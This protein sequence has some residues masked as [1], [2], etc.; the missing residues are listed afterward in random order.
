M[1]GLGEGGGKA[2]GIV[3]SLQVYARPQH[4]LHRCGIDESAVGGPVAPCG[5]AGA[6][7]TAGEGGAPGLVDHGIAKGGMLGVDQTGGGVELGG[8]DGE[9]EPARDRGI[10]RGATGLGS[11]IVCEEV[12]HQHALPADGRAIA[13]PVVLHP[14]RVEQPLDL[15]SGAGIEG[16]GSPGIDAAARQEVAGRSGDDQIVI[17]GERVAQQMSGIGVIGDQVEQEAARLDVVDPGRRRS[18]CR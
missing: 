8:H 11:E 1:S 7:E 18:R 5:G 16:I 2:P 10:Q 4:I 12:S 14:P 17:G 15:V 3:E 9:G 6:A 13:A